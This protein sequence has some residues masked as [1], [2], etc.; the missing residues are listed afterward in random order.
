M[1]KKYPFIKQ[2][3]LK[4]CGVASLMMIIKYYKGKISFEEL[5]DLTK[6]NKNGTTAYHVIEAANK[7]GFDAKGIKCKLEDLNKENIVLPAIAHVIIDKTY[8][9]FVVIYKINFK[10]K[11][12]LIADPNNKLK[13]IKFEE[14][15][16]IWQNILI[17]LYPLYSLKKYK[18]NISIITFVL[19]ILKYCSKELKN[20]WLLSL[21]ITIF[22][23]STSFF[24]KY[25]IDSIILKY[26]QNHLFSLFIIFFVIYILLIIT[27]YFRN[28]VLIYLNELVS[29]ILT[30]NTFKQIIQLPYIYYC[31]RTTGE[32]ISRINDLTS[33]NQVISKVFYSIFIDLPLALF[34][35]FILASINLKLFGIVLI[36]LTLY[37]INIIIFK[38]INKHYIK[39]IQEKRALVSSY[40]VEGISNFET[41]K[42]LNLENKI[43]T[44]FEKLYLKLLTSTKDG[45]RAV[46]N[47]YIFKEVINKIGFIVIIYLGTLLILKNQLT[48]GQLLTF[49]S[50]LIYF[51][52]PI[53]N[54][55]SVNSNISEAI[56]SIKRIL[57]LYYYREEKGIVKELANGKINIK[58][59]NYS[60]NDHNLILN[61]INLKIDKGS[62]VLIVGSSG[63]GKS[64]LLKIIMKYYEVD[65]NK[66][67]IN[68]IDINDYI[69][70]DYRKGIS[71]ISQQE[72]L[73]TG[74]LINNFNL[75][76]KDETKI[77]D[78]AKMCEVD[79]IIEKTN[80]GYK[81]LIE[82]D[83]YNISGGEK[84]RIILARSLLK[85]F[86]ILLIDE[87]MSQMDINLE[88]RILKKIF[89]KY[90][91][92]TIIIVSHRLANAD[93]F[94][95]LVEL[96][97]GK[98]K[99]EV[100]KSG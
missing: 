32:V 16:K 8:N 39:S 33:V 79:K 72:S 77:I 60:Y 71:Y 17:V 91:D 59:L 86:N 56:N 29:Y 61:K 53:N 26:P 35:L 31:N 34:V 5:R 51:F 54:I 43:I 9:H 2:K 83:G 19:R 81:M 89:E 30:A 10:K 12:L 55:I 41:I 23:I 66:V 64:T 42:A 48:V 73:F 97:N 28:K 75:V 36:L 20:I 63:S 76:N 25:M 3:G 78:I 49:N 90:I 52:E 93:L 58:N 38:P 21:F 47:Q 94:D 37:I 44:K 70:D 87:G 84:Q 96:E 67:F 7:L 11:T 6:T 98:V 74:T 18:E 45:D 27:D 65:R 95:K 99:K 69:L 57:D 50:L 68:N 92:K 88:R 14:F 24:L 80:T 22:S 85:P 82:E 4:D 13:T 46:N 100:F 15:E 40:M 1:F 62:K